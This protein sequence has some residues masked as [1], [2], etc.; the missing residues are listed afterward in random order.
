MT[1]SDGGNFEEAASWQKPDRQETSFVET[2]ML[3]VA[4]PV[5]A[6]SIVMRGSTWHFFGIN[7][8]ELIVKP[9]AFML[10]TATT[11]L[12]GESC[13]VAQGKSLAAEPCL[14]AIAAGDGRE[15]FEFNSQGQLIHIASS[16]CITLL[17]GD[18]SMGGKLALETCSVAAEA[19]DGRSSWVLTGGG[20]L[21]LSN[22]GSYCL[23]VSGKRPAVLSCMDEQPGE[24]FT[25]IAVPEFDRSP[26]AESKNSAILLGAAAARQRGFLAQLQEAMALLQTC[27]LAA[28]PTRNSS[29]LMKPVVSL[30][31]QGAQVQTSGRAADAAM[32]TIAY[33]Y[34]AAGVDIEG[35]H[36]LI[37]DTVEALNAVQTKM[38]H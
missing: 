33:M 23:D 38:S 24:Q 31:A 37:A 6:L 18:A 26:A 28:G 27:T 11:A 1:S 25:L 4:H 22:L 17:N 9:Y 2:I 3:D 21:K 10:A 35:V 19:N 34:T 14:N 30:K 13:L 29:Y 8:V 16:K 15:I 36:R 20:Q 5:K 7:S 12:T 32:Q